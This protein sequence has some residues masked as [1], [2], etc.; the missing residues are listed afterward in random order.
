[1]VKSRKAGGESRDCGQEGASRSKFLQ[2]VIDYTSDSSSTL[3]A[4]GSGKPEP[5]RQSSGL[6]ASMLCRSPGDCISGVR[7]MH[8]AAGHHSVSTEVSKYT[9]RILSLALAL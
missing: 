1:M 8:P 6:A 5:L 3:E 9:T 7:L 4:E 2:D